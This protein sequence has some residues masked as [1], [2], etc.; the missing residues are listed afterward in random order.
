MI[1]QRSLRLPAGSWPRLTRGCWLSPSCSSRFFRF[2][3]DRFSRLRRGR[4]SRF[5]YRGLS[6][7][8]HGRLSRSS[9]SGLFRFARHFNW[10]LQFQLGRFPSSMVALV[11]SLDAGGFFVCQQ[12]NA[13]TASPLVLEV[14]RNRFRCHV[15]SIAK[16]SSSKLSNCDHS[17]PP[18][19]QEASGLPTPGSVLN[20]PNSSLP[21]CGHRR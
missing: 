5:G 17:G 10:S 11:Q 18:R 3:G 14:F 8:A 2:G 4:H 6:C 1:K 13:F 12:L 19:K 16:L 9:H 20:A 15:R 21:E 7:F